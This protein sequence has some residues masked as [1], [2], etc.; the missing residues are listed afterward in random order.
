MAVPTAANDEAPSPATLRLVDGT[1]ISVPDSNAFLTTY[2]LREQGD[3]FEDELNLLRHLVQPGQRVIDIGANH[4]VYALS[5][6]RRVGPTGAVWA[7]EPASDTARHLAASIAA[8]ETPWLRL[9]RQ[10][11]SDHEGTAWLRTPGQSELNSLAP[12]GSSASPPPDVPGEAVPVTTLDACLDAFGWA[13]VDLVK[14]DA[15]GEEMRILEGGR[16]FFR[17]TSPLVM[18]E[19]KEGTRLHLELVERF[20]AL[21]YRCFRLVPGL[22]ALVPQALSAGV[23]GYLLNLF[24][25]KPDRVAALAAGG[26]LV[27]ED[28][29]TD[30]AAHPM[31]APVE[32][33]AAA[34]HQAAI[35][36][37]TTAR[38]RD[39]PLAV[40]LA[41]LRRAERGLREICRVEGSLGRY[42]SLARVALELGERE[43]AVEALGQLLDQLQ[44]EGA[45][46]GNEAFLAPHPAYDAIDPGG[47][48]TEW[49]ESAALEALECFGSFSSFFTGPAALPRLRRLSALGLATPAMAERLRMVQARFPE[50]SEPEGPAS[51]PWFDALGL[52]RP[53][54]CLDV[55]AMAVGDTLDPWVRWAREGCAEVI[56]FEPS[57]EDCERLNQR[58][59]A[60]DGRVRYLPVALGDGEEHTLH[61]T[62]APMTSSLFPPETSTVDLFPF[63]GDLMRVE[64]RERLRTSRLDDLS[65]VRPVD[66]LKLDVQGAELMV[67]RHGLATLAEV[68]VV[69]CEVEFVELYAGQPLMSDV[70]AFLRSQGFAFLQFSSLQGRPFLPLRKAENPYQP[71]SQTL[72]GDAVY[73]RDFRRREQWSL[74][75][76]KAAVFVLHELY[77]AYD[78][79][80]LLLAEVDRREEGAWQSLY[81]T[82]LL[83]SDP[84]VRVD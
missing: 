14:I 76:L 63:L 39:L 30:A 1:L 44:Q 2:V 18:F 43:R 50:A 33:A 31:E 10:A 70:D 65:Q 41:A 22:P 73:V 72:W 82:S 66:F 3:W 52:E 64:R 77:Q 19:I 29:A 60:W 21:G 37:W 28:G 17:E 56:G 34:R 45:L 61:V 54:R 35:A 57:P 4:G 32:G 62:N 27:V 46:D 8:N 7:F 16:R 40:R 53:V 6:A 42:A 55:G 24:A 47:R 83:L 84:T 36:A 5:L 80:S 81:L 69:Q 49:L 59:A 67:L 20:Q 75:Q 12:G 79:V 51:R 78:L 58:V 74:H 25:A 48:P 13:D 11:L 23:D 38:S 15:E 68:T 71:I 9:Q 26:W